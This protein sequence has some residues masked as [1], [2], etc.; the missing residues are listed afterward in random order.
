MG[1]IHENGYK[2][3]VIDV[4]LSGPQTERRI[5]RRYNG[6]EGRWMAKRKDE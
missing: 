1:N 6:W 2:D 5:K 3:K 4:Q